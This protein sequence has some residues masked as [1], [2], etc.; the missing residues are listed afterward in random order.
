[1]AVATVAPVSPVRNFVG[2]WVNFHTVL[3]LL[4]VL[5]ALFAPLIAPYNPVQANTA[6]QLLPP[7]SLH[8]FGTDSNG[9]DVFSRVIWAARTD[10]LIS[11]LGVAIG[12][13][14]GSIVGAFCGYAGRL[15]DE[16]VSRLS[17]MMQAM[18]TFLFALLIVAVL[19]HS[20]AVLVGV[21]AFINIP[22]YLK[23]TRSIAA[24]LRDRDYVAAAQC[25]GYG[26]T[27]IV[28]RH[29]LPNSIGP[30]SSQLPLSCGFAIQ[31]VAGLSFLGLGVP[32]PQPEWGSM[33]QDGAAL[34]L[35]GQWWV[36]VF[37]GLAVVL[38][39]IAFDGIGRRLG[40]KYGR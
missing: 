40:E 21:V 34:I 4:L 14:A 22:V 39:I 13:S 31:I 7:S 3:L 11:V 1:V 27:G 30:L 8:W 37:P 18:P 10:L 38:T 25:A 9:M 19:G 28:L 5:C 12:A 20:I 15:S 36:A 2:R 29:V 16:A 23:L 33:I 17:E 32:V 35:Y 26:R 6:D 24:P